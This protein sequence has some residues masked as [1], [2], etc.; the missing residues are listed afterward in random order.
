MTEQY[1]Y[2]RAGQGI[3]ADIGYNMFTKSK[4]VFNT[5]SKAYILEPKEDITAYELWN[6]YRFIE[7]IKLNIYHH[8][9]LGNAL[10]NRAKEL[11]INRHLK[12]S[13]YG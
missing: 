13:R 3:G 2:L 8:R 12:K 9:D 10:Y 5:D 6:V 4:I 11:K 1:D 7:E